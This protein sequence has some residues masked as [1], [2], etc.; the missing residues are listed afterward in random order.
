MRTLEDLANDVKRLADANEKT[1]ILLENLINKKSNNAVEE[2]V[3]GPVNTVQTQISNAQ[4]QP[5]AIPR[6]QEASISQVPNGLPVSGVV[7]QY[8]RE[9]ISLAMGRAIDMG[10][11]DKIQNILTQSFGVQ[12]LMELAPDKYNDLVLKLKEIGIEVATC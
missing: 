1:N 2:I 3:S 12:S 4:P 7:P 10:L 11:M 9:Q 5:T 8:T 6:A